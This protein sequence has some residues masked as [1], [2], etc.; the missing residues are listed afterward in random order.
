[1]NGRK[2][3]KDFVFILNIYFY[4]VIKSNVLAS[5]RILYWQ[6]WLF[7]KFLPYC[8]QLYDNYNYDFEFLKLFEAPT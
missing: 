4:L 3:K 2:K 8:F 1:M 7:K 6:I 5:M